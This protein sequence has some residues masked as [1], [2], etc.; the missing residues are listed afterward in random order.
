MSIEILRVDTDDDL[1]AQ[2]DTLLWRVLWAPLG[3]PADIR[4]QFRLPGPGLELVAVMHD[5]ITGG[6]VFHRLE[7]GQCELRHIAV[8]PRY[9]SSGIGRQLF[10]EG[11][12]LLSDE[13]CQVISTIARNTSSAFFA[14]L[15]FVPVSEP[16]PDHPIF[17]KHG[18]RFQKM[19]WSGQ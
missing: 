3:L 1:K 14:K 13:G 12:A 15:G 2:L 5:Q 9:Q 7:A 18:I 11:A 17:L 16:V 6:A 10:R 19:V 8:K 4:H